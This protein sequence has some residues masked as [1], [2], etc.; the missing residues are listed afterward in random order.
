LLS[1]QTPTDPDI[2]AATAINRSALYLR[3]GTSPS[4][5]EPVAVTAS[6]LLASCRAEFA[7]LFRYG[8]EPLPDDGKGT[9]DQMAGIIKR[10]QK[11]LTAALSQTQGE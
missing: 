9:R 5:Q 11:C 10:H 6:M 2:A 4:N 1:R 3:P 8:L 7:A